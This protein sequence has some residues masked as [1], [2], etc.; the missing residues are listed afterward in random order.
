[1]P[2]PERIK[3]K[4]VFP[5]DYNPRYANG[6]IGG[7]TPHGEIL[8]HFYQER[9]ALP[10][11]TWHRIVKGRIGECEATD[12]SEAVAIRFVQTGVTMTPAAARMLYE[13]LGK[14]LEGLQQ[15]QE[16]AIQAMGGHEE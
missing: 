5:D 10:K 9:H 11:Y 2:E 4:Y 6:V 16:D 3:F 7:F 8:I 13:W 15:A 12:D 14:T 1:M